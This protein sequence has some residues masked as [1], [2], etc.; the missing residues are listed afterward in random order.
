MQNKTWAVLSVILMIAITV[1]GCEAI[2]S[3][4]KAGVWTGTIAVILIL[5]LVVYIVSKLFS[6]KKD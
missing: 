2:G 3:I 6:R 4:F 1:S 5:L